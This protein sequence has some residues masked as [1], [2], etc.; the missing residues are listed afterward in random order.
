MTLYKEFCEH[1]GSVC[2]GGG[3]L[4]TAAGGFIRRNGVEGLSKSLL[5]VGACLNPLFLPDNLDLG[6]KVV[7]P[8]YPGPG[9][10]CSVCCGLTLDLE[11]GLFGC[12]NAGEMNRL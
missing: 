3:F 1:L 12:W 7:L 11:W 4:A 5:V 9:E 6:L 10:T 2:N 8:V